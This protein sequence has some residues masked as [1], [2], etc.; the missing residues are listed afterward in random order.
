MGLYLRGSVWWMSFVD[1]NTG[2]QKRRSTET[3]DAKR[4]KRIFDKTKGQIAEG[5]W[6]EKLPG[7]DHTFQEMMERYMEEHSRPKKASSERDEASLKRLSP[8]FG[9]RL[10]A[11]IT[12]QQINQYKNERRLAGASFS[13]INRELALMKHAFNLAWKEWEWVIDNPVLRVSMEKEPP[14]RDRWLTREEQKEL[15]SVSPKW[16]RE[17]ILFAVETGLRR[18][19]QLNLKW[20]N[21][22]LNN[23][24]L[25]VLG[26]K[27]GEKR[28]IPLTRQALE[29]LAVRKSL[30][31][32]KLQS[33]LVFTYPG[34]QMVNI[35][36]LRTAFV[37]ALEKVKM[38][39]LHWHDLRHT[40]ASRL[41]QAG[42]DPYTIQRL[43][44][45]KSFTTTQ[46]YA[47]HYVESLR[48]GISA[49]DMQRPEAV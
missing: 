2:K 27:T 25:T 22:D 45:H 37:T 12:P 17:L 48:R 19:E 36:T 28:S 32:Q 44:G 18:G 41:A 20:K 1:P 7:E 29:V 13:C 43:M 46:R 23:K 14:S 9:S 11:E 42:V 10:M 34:A 30:D 24:V 26:T 21:I 31:E 16:L 4:A 49:L 39:D 3:T 35:Y 40:F 15:L 47:H 33:D 5:K 6:F 8:F 38:E